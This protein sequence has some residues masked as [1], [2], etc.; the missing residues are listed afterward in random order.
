MPSEAVLRAAMT[1]AARYSVLIGLTGVV[2]ACGDARLQKVDDPEPQAI[3]EQAPAELAP[4]AVA[5]APPA[6]TTVSTCRGAPYP[7]VLAHGFTGFRDLGPLNYFNR[8]ADTLRDEA[9]IVYE[10]EVAPYH[11]SVFRGQQ[12]AAFI[13]KV[14]ATENACK[15]ILIGHSQGGIDAR[16]VISTLGYGD[17]VAALAT[18][19]TPHRGTRICDAYLGL[20]PGWT[21]PM[22]DF[23]ARIIGDVINEES[24]EASL[25]GFM[26]QLNE[27]EM[28]NVFN[29][30]N[31]DDPRVEY[32]SVAGRTGLTRQDDECSGAVWKN[33][34]EVDAVEPLLLPTYEFLNGGI[35]D[36]AANDGLVTVESAR[37]G[38]FL[39]C[40]PADHLDEI[41]QIADLK[42]LVGWDH[43]DMYRDVVDHLR[44]RGH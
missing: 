34:L 9:E 43:V 7:I 20:V 21:D 12:L 29:P 36:R 18:I 35:I 23:F 44:A 8:V 38:T 25:R 24:D 11:G 26:D 6:V 41:G 2:L 33:P 42:P 17:R 30:A 13:D 3:S 40:V 31:P 22:M 32:F 14:L 37:W 15:V 28:V 4:A 39:G 5:S 27:Q 1:P 10:A 16:Y 19:S